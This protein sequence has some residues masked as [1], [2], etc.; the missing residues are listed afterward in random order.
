MQTPKSPG[1]GGSPKCVHT[2]V[3]LDVYFANAVSVKDGEKGLKPL[4]LLRLSP[5]G[6][7]MHSS[8][9]SVTF[10][11]PLDLAMYPLD[12][13][14]CALSLE[15]FSYRARDMYLG[16]YS[17]DGSYPVELS[18]SLTLPEIRILNFTIQEN[19][20]H[21]SVGSYSSVMVSRK[22]PM[23]LVKI[24][25]FFIIILF[26]RCCKNNRDLKQGY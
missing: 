16:A 21:F 6:S 3:Y 26:L 5:D 7:V 17:Q 15:S 12:V 22:Q 1:G 9:V 19:L 24:L 23:K 20:R 18:A 10:Q 13:Q 2:C 4:T 25:L 14:W 11:C 8:D